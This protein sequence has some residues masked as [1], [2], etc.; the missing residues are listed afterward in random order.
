MNNRNLFPDYAS[1]TYMHMNQVHLVAKSMREWYPEC[2]LFHQMKHILQILHILNDMASKTIHTHNWSILNT[3]KKYL[4]QN[5]TWK[6]WYS[7]IISEQQTLV[8]GFCW[9]WYCVWCPNRFC[10]TI[11]LVVSNR[12]TNV[13]SCPPTLSY[14]ELLWATSSILRVTNIPYCF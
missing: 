5:A 11:I 6:I 12:W 4:K 8:V 1:K 9:P 2:H 13:P 7:F 3:K 14:S 10:F